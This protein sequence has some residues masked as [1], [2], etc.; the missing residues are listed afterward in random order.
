MTVSIYTALLLSLLCQLTPFQLTSRPLSGTI[1]PV[2]HTR[3]P[4]PYANDDALGKLLPATLS[5][6]SFVL[7]ILLAC[8]R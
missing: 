2:Q 5:N 1:E 7:Y 4:G 6:A 3:P 8:H